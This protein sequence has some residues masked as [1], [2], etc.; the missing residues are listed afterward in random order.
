MGQGPLEL[1]GSLLQG[2]GVPSAVRQAGLAPSA[3]YDFSY[4][5]TVVALAFESAAGPAGDAVVKPE[6]LKLLQFVAIRPWLLP[7]VLTW[8]RQPLTRQAS[9]LPSTYLRRG[10]LSDTIHEGV[11]GFALAAEGLNQVSR[12][13]VKGPNNFLLGNLAATARAQ[14]WFSGERRALEQLA[15]ARI[16]ASMLEGW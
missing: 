10:F 4:R 16:T 3:I 11:V 14:S 2:R 1:L 9:I 7:D 12:G 8:A 6:K 13:L 15:A 5:F